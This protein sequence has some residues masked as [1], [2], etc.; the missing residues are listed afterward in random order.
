MV[1]TNAHGNQSRLSLVSYFGAKVEI[2]VMWHKNKIHM[3]N[4]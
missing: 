2:V 1:T 4:T 3:P